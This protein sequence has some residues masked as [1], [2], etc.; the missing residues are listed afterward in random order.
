MLLFAAPSLELGDIRLEVAVVRDAELPGL[1]PELVAGAIEHARSQFELR[2]DSTAPTF[3]VVNELPVAGF[4]GAFALPVDPACKPLY[5]VRYRGGGKNEID[6]HRAKALEFFQKW[7]IESLRGFLSADVAAR[8]RTHAEVYDFYA[9]HYPATVETIR[10]LSTQNGTPLI[11]PARSTSRSFAAWTCA[12]RRQSEYD[13]VVTNAFILADIVSEPHP[14]TVFG[15]AKIGGIAGSSPGRPALGGQVLLASTFG[16]DT[17]LPF[18]REVD[19]DRPTMDERAKI[20]GAYILAHEIAHAVFGIPDVFDHPSGCL[21]TTRPGTTYRDGLIELER[22]LRPC[23]R[24][25]PYVESRALVDR[26]RHEL[27]RKRYRAAG[28]LLKRGLETLPKHVHG[29]RKK[30]VSEILVLASRAS[31]GLGQERRAKSYA[32][33]A[34]ELDPSSRQAIDLIASLTSSTATTAAR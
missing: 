32:D 31:M 25:R 16:I 19:G 34:L 1:E 20:L 26:G 2:F 3:D 5:A 27:E 7:D 13:V 22:K 23:P 12:L 11:D 24:C 15:K 9:S 33:L 17:E 28:N 29:S 8:T 10:G 6:K 4:L 14:H 21:M 18:F 30:R